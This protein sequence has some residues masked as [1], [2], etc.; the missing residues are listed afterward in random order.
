MWSPTQPVIFQRLEE[1]VLQ[2][3]R[4][5]GQGVPGVGRQLRHSRDDADDG[6][7]GL[8]F[9]RAGLCFKMHVFADF[10]RQQ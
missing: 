9:R 1:G 10:H 3:G 6:F 2:E 8:S 4:L 7:G 5:A